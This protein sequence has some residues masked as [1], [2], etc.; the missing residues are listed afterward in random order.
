VKIDS[1][2]VT[3]Q[4]PQIKLNCPGGMAGIATAVSLKAPEA[5]AEADAAEP[6]KD[7]TYQKQ[8]DTLPTGEYAALPGQAWMPIERPKPSWIEI[9]LVDEIDQPVR[10]EPYEIVA[11]DGHTLSHGVT[12]PDGV[13]H[14]IVPEP[15][16]CKIRFPELDAEAWERI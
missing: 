7:K 15:G 11:P 1:Q 2:G 12:G 9:E 5:P 6:G 8:A 3:I 4:G 14:V 10:G 16:A 13:A